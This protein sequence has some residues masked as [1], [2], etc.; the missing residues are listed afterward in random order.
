MVAEIRKDTEDG[1]VFIVL[2]CEP[3]TGGVTAYD[4]VGGHASGPLDTI[5]EGSE[6]VPLGSAEGREAANRFRNIYGG[7]GIK[8]RFPNN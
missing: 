6:L 5:R 2:P 8:A 7:C 1:V 4:F 3:E